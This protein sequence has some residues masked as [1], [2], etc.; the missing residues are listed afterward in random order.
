MFD[1]SETIEHDM[2]PSA[3]VCLRATRSA[4]LNVLVAIGMLGAV[5]AV[6]TWRGTSDTMLLDLGQRKKP[7]NVFIYYSKQDKLVFPQL[8]IR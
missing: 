4:V 6:L 8:L 1:P 3:V 2:D 7:M 5:L